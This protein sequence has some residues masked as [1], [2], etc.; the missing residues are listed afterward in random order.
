MGGPSILYPRPPADRHRDYNRLVRRLATA[1][2]VACAVLGAEVPA[3]T[4][5]GPVRIG[6][7]YGG[8][9]RRPPEVAAEP[10]AERNAWRRDLRTIRSLGFN[11]IVTW[12]N[13]ASAEPARG[14]YRLEALD[15]LALLAAR[16]GLGV[17]ARVFV[18]PPPAWA[19]GGSASVQALSEAFTSYVGTR[20]P[21]EEEAAAQIDVRAAAGPADLRLWGWAAL[22]RGSRAIAFHAWPDLAGQDARA[23]VAAEFAGVVT[24]N[25]A[26]FDPLAPRPS[27]AGGPGISPGGEAA[28]VHAAFL[29]SR[30]ALVLVA[31][32]YR[33]EPATVTLTFPP[34]TKQEFWQNMETGEMVT[35]AMEGGR[36]SLT[37]TFAPRDAL[38]LTIRKT[39]PYDRQPR[40]AAPRL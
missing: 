13:W 18:D 11:S 26:L 19:T 32:N 10:R 34:G 2:L 16:A 31:L 15:E 9:T 29:E 36:P 24:R 1:T 17:R 27:S 39:S 37:H 22:A 35:F 30:D 12:V 40:P 6:V 8:G 3:Q 20:V 25:L 33:T 7:W 23:R 28:Q 14:E 21:L 38:V 4:P 5:T